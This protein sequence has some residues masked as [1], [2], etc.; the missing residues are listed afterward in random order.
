[1]L[2][3][4][5]VVKNSGVHVTKIHNVIHNQLISSIL[6]ERLQMEMNSAAQVENWFIWNVYECANIDWEM[7]G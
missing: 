4:E 1:M 3:W 6:R 2:P 5:H 7:D